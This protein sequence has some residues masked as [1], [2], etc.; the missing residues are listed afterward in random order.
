MCPVRTVGRPPDDL[1][2]RQSISSFVTRQPGKG[3][4]I[5]QRAGVD[6]DIGGDGGCFALGP[7]RRQVDAPDSGDKVKVAKLFQVT[8][9]L[10]GDII[11][12]HILML[13]SV[14]LDRFS[15]ADGAEVSGAE[16]GEVVSAP[17]VA[18]LAVDDGDVSHS[19]VC[20]L[21]IFDDEAAEFAG[22]TVVFA[23][24]R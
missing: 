13:M 9:L 10:A 6:S 15:E 11:D 22:W 4:V 2:S 23:A 5:G 18:V 24:N 12:P 8:V 1:V 16:E 3:A 17:E 19:R 7:Q 20:I 21:G 14:I